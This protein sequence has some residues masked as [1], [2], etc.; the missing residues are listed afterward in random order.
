MVIINEEKQSGQKI[1][2]SIKKMSEQVERA[3]IIEVLNSLNWKIGRAAK[4]LQ[5]DRSTLFGKMK[6]YGIEKG[7]DISQ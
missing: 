3:Y 4:I 1:R 7:G 6:K 2:S 5:I